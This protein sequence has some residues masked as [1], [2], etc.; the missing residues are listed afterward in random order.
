MFSLLKPSV[1]HVCYFVLFVLMLYIDPGEQFF[2]HVG[3]IVEP[4]QCSG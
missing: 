1:D 2:S 3:T 4:V